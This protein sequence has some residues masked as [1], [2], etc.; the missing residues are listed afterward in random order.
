MRIRVRVRG[1]GR[2]LLLVMGIGGN[3]EMW[4][5]LVQELEGYQTIAFD[6][7]GTGG[8]SR[9]NRPLRMSHL[10]RVVEGLLDELH[11][12]QV[13]VLGVS[14]GGGLAQQLARQAPHRV[15]RLI[16]AATSCGIGS[17]PGNPL[18]M[19]TLMS[20]LRYYSKR[21]LQLTT[22]FAFGGAARHNP[23]VIDDQWMARQGKPPSLTGYILQLFAVAGWSSLPYLHHIEQ[24]TLVLMGADD[25]LVPAINGRI[26]AWRL[27]HARLHVLE[28]AGHLFLIEE[29]AAS[30]ALIDEFLREA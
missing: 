3:A 12:H 21:Y 24:L 17:V 22:G 19:L 27:P 14:F 29:A 1:N 9:P 15:R 18:A 28:G 13:D 2:P 11:Y 26:L 4:E 10:A 8:S 20:P 5:P 16:L 7:P 23:K 6:A 30:A 25:P